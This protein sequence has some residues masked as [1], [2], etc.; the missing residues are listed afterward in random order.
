[1]ST[2]MQHLFKRNSHQRGLHYIAHRRLN[3]VEDFE[4]A[5]TMSRA[6]DKMPKYTVDHS[7]PSRI[8]RTLERTMIWNVKPCR[9]TPLM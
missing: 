9:N 3:V 6:M 5:A 1:M 8:G 4:I 7:L 2:Q